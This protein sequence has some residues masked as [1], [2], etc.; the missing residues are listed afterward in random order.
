MKTNSVGKYVIFAMFG[1]V[2]L[3]VGL[4]LTKLLQDAHGVMLTLPYICVGIG[5]GTVGDV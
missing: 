3:I 4:I 1:F 2:L 5:A